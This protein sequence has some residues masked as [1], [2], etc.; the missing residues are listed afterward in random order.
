MASS[1]DK[2]QVSLI[3]LSMIFLMGVFLPT[4]IAS[5]INNN[6]LIG[7]ILFSIIVY[8]YMIFLGEWN[9]IRGNLILSTIIVFFYLFGTIIFNSNEI[10]WGT[11]IYLILFLLLT[12][13]KFKQINLKNIEKK[14]LL[15][16]FGIANLLLIL[17][18][19]GQLLG[20]DTIKDFTIN[21]YSAYYNDLLYY[22]FLDNKPITV[23]ATHS[24]AAFYT[25]LFL[26]LNYNLY[27]N[28]K[29]KRFIFYELGWL[30]ILIYLNSA[31]SLAFVGIFI[32]YL[33]IDNKKKISNSIKLLL[34]MSII[35]FVFIFK[36]NILEF[37]RKIFLEDNNGWSSRYGETGV[38]SSNIEWIANHMFVGVG[39][40]YF[41]NLVYGDSGVIELW[42]R[43]GII[44]LICFC[45]IYYNFLRKNLNKLTA[46]VIFL[47]FF[48]FELGFTNILSARTLLLLP[49]IVFLSKVIFIK[50]VKT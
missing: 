12:S 1:E 50:D 5:N 28:F 39:F 38:L 35:L 17:L 16:V 7:A 27:K 36:N 29:N 44:T 2:I 32:I 42:M 9:L 43:G 21:F 40:N 49:F 31:T 11:I 14:L 19:F 20:I 48:I 34:L 3:A 45:L 4:S 24:V 15:R 23:F 30:I 41:P 26:F 8:I 37:F 25:F 22:M 18:G 33:V 46:S 10:K 13:I 47:I 6:F